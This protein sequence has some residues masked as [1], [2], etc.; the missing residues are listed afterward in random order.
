MY[1]PNGWSSGNTYNNDH[2]QGLSISYFPIG[3]DNQALTQVL[4][5]E[6]CGHGFAKLADEYSY[7][8]Y[9]KVPYSEISSTMMLQEFG[10]YR[11]VDFI[12]DPQEILWSHFLADTRYQYD[13]LGAFEGG[14]TY[15][16]GVWRP[17]DNS[18]MRHNTDGFN[19]PSRERIYY[20]INKLAYGTSWQYDYEEFVKFDAVSRKSAA[21]AAVA[22]APL[23]TRPVE[24][25][26]PVVRPYSC[27]EIVSKR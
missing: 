19:A 1:Y 24:H 8:E 5:H 4:S 20:R 15:W 14:M 10:W 11:N 9:G 7:Y 13:G 2:G 18:I 16:T 25:T 22:D 27:E 6:A 3:V 17:T 26:P 12:N 21:S 23:V